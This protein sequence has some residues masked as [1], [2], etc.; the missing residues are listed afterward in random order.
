MK[1]TRIY[2]T[3]IALLFGAM[4]S[5]TFA[6]PSTKVDVASSLVKGIEAK[7]ISVAKSSGIISDKE[8]ATLVESE[9]MQQCVDAFVE[10]GYDPSAAVDK[11]AEIS[12]QKGYFKNKADAKKAFKNAAEKARKSET[13]WDKV[14]GMLGL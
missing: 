10:S 8:A 7:I 13:L 14:Y 4:M 3:S 6:N 11:L 5:M 2:F 9:A 12:V 1:K